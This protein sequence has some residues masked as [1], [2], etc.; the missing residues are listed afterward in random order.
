M[1]RFLC[2][3]ASQVGGEFGRGGVAAWRFLFEALAADRFEIAGH[4][5]VELAWRGSLF[6]HDLVQQRAQIAAEG[7]F[8]RQRLKQDH[9]QRI[10]V[11]ASVGVV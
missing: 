11:G 6:V 10:H 4:A 2:Q 1:D 9:S 8:A 3:V 5:R 7:Q